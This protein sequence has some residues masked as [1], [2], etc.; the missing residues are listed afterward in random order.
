MDKQPSSQES[1]LPT[2]LPYSTTGRRTSEC[3]KNSFRPNFQLDTHEEHGH[4]DPDKR[5]ERAAEIEAVECYLAN[6][7]ILRD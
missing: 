6:T 1:L 2:I 5:G 3:L 4:L 7:L